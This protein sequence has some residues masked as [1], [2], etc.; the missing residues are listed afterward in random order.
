MAEPKRDLALAQC[1]SLLK[2]SSGM[3]RVS[4]RAAIAAKTLAEE[5]LAKL[6]RHCGEFLRAAKRKTLTRKDL[7]YVISAQFACVGVSANLPAD[8]S[9][10]DH[11]FPAA[12]A[13]RLFKRAAGKGIRVDD[14]CKKLLAYICSELVQHLGHKAA[15][16][17]HAGAASKK[18]QIKTLKSR[19]VGAAAKLMMH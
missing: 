7:A 17:A 10:H 15:C 3:D 12:T 18:G 4:E 8:M 2:S 1:H 16:I 11:M 19:H 9:A 5:F 6:A 13:T 14:E